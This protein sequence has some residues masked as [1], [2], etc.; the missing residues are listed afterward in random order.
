M[1]AEGERFSDMSAK[2]E[3]FLPPPPYL[4]WCRR[5]LP[6]SP[7]RSTGWTPYS[8]PAPSQAVQPPSLP[9]MIRG[10]VGGG[11][12]RRVVKNKGGSLGEGDSREEVSE[13][14]GGAKR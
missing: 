3:F 6:D 4:V 1:S 5:T 13:G 10:S 12:W 9:E 2:S 14:A 11:V 7:R 8:S